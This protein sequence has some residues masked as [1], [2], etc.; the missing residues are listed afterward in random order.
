M[1][2]GRPH[3]LTLESVGTRLKKKKKSLYARTATVTA[4]EDKFSSSLMSS[5]VI[6]NQTIITHTHTNMHAEERAYFICPIAALT[7]SD[8]DLLRPDQ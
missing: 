5:P 1:C 8:Y 3:S 6:T 2:D 4:A 7:K